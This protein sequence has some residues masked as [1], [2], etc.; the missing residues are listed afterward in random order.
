MLHLRVKK[1]K[2]LLIIRKE[3]RRYIFVKKSD[4]EGKLHYYL[5]EAEY[6][7]GTAK[8]E[9]RDIGDRVVTMNLA[10]K[11]S[12]RDDIYRYIVEE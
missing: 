11:T 6:I 2:I 12:I 3:I 10:M 4:A 8:E 5:G 7:K 1:S 9:T